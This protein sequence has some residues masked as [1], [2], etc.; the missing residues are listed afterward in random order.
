MSRAMPNR[1]ASNVDTL[2]DGSKVDRPPRREV[3]FEKTK[4]TRKW[5]RFIK[6]WCSHLPRSKAEL[7]ESQAQF[8]IEKG[9]AVATT[10]EEQLASTSTE[11]A[12]LK[13]DPAQQV[14]RKPDPVSNK[15]MATRPDLK[16]KGQAQQ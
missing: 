1:W 3:V 14:E 10:R 5:V 16:Q 12:P 9:F 7:L 6:A 2:S 4:P 8:V 15:S 11:P 13:S